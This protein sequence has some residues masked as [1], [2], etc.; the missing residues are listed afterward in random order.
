MRTFELVL[1][2][3]GSHFGLS[4]AQAQV[5]MQ[6]HCAAANADVDADAAPICMTLPHPEKVHF[7]TRVFEF[8]VF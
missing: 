8:H 4:L 3:L 2:I 7:S 5:L 1:Y 6:M